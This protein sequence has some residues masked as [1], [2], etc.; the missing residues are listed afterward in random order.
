M[1]QGLVRDGTINILRIERRD[2]KFET[3]IFINKISKLKMI[4][5][6]YYGILRSLMIILRVSVGLDENSGVLEVLIRI[7]MGPQTEYWGPK[8]SYWVL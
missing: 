6:P 2:W 5:N 1:A 7:F 8:H 4:T 3:N